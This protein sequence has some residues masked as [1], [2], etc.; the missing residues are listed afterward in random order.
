M[1]TENT[2][3]T[4]PDN[5]FDANESKVTDSIENK[6]S[7]NLVLPDNFL[8]EKKP[9]QDYDTLSNILYNGATKSGNDYVNS[10]S[11]GSSLK[12]TTSFII[13]DFKDNFK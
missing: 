5:F 13:K 2:D 3:L 1:A 6:E 12:G 7:N 4:L 8:D 9:I 11:S 10:F